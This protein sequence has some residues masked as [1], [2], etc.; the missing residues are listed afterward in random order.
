MQESRKQGAH[1][2]S[3]L[4]DV[5]AEPE[6]ATDSTLTSRPARRFGLKVRTNIKAGGYDW[7]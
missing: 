2:E 4:H 5:A 7:T 6:R 1:V 3:T